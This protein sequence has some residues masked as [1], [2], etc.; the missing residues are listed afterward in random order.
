MI[1][2]V[3]FLISFIAWLYLMINTKGHKWYI[4]VLAFMWGFFLCQT[5]FGACGMSTLIDLIMK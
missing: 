3:I 1:N 4:H 5:I 2:L